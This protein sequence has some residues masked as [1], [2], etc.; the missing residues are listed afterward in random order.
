MRSHCLIPLIGPDP[1]HK[2]RFIIIDD[3]AGEAP[4]DVEDVSEEAGQVIVGISPDGKER[5]PG[6]PGERRRQR[7][8]GK[9]VHLPEGGCQLPL[10]I[11]FH[12]KAERITLDVHDYNV[13]LVDIRILEQIS[14]GLQA[15]GEDWL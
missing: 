2:T 13:F 12:A 4:G 15:G 8:I 7:F 3:D 9:A 1:L 5:F 6:D 11:K 10:G 14:L